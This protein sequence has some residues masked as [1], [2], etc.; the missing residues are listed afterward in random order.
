M[1]RAL[2]VVALAALAVLVAIVQA[3]ILP[4]AIQSKHLS[5][6]VRAA[7]CSYKT[8]TIVLN[9]G[10]RFWIVPRD[11]AVWGFLVASSGVAGAIEVG[12]FDGQNYVTV[13]T[14]EGLPTNFVADDCGGLGLY[15]RNAGSQTMIVSYTFVYHTALTPAS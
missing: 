7:L 9:P 1:R 8:G 2:A 11:E 10:E 6:P 3:G 12:S 5:D 15:I 4:G 14:N 13:I